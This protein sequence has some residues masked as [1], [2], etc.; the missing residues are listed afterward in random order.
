M[1]NKNTYKVLNNGNGVT[2]VRKGEFNDVTTEAGQANGNNR[3][4]VTVK[5]VADLANATDDDKKKLPRWLMLL[6]R[7]T[8][9]Q[10]S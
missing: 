2:A 1:D 6:R 9:R 8:R 10:L 5:N 3:G 7:L 4:K